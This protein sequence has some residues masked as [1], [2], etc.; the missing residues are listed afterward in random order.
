MTTGVTGGD[1]LEKVRTRLASSGE[2]PTTAAVAAALR[3][4]SGVHGDAEIQRVLTVLRSEIAGAGPLEALLREPDVTDVLVNGPAEIWA[5]R[6][7]GLE[8]CAVSFPGE[9]AVRRLAQRL[10]AASG[11][12]LDD[13]QPHVDARLADGTRLHA[14]LPPISPTGTVLSL[15]VPRRRAFTMA[16]LSAADSVA[17]SLGRVCSLIVR[18]RL[19]FLVTGGTGSGKTTLL[20]ALLGLVDVGERVLLVEDAA[21]LQPACPH[22]VRL[23]ARTSN[24]EGVGEVTLR[25]L[26]RQALR[27][28]PDRIVV[29]EVRG[30]EVLDL[31]TALNTGHEG[32]CGTLHANGADD[33]P[34]RLESL[35]ALAGMPRAALHS[36]LASA[37]R[38]VLHLR[39]DA[40]GVRQLVEVDV[41]TRSADGLVQAD[42]ALRR[43]GPQIRTGPG[44]PRLLGLLTAAGASPESLDLGLDSGTAPP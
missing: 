30:P 5:D 24:V 20:A 7:R 34:A 27:M 11:R 44:W 37:L 19:A 16:E 10:A 4:E 9:A 31:L 25:T 1:L 41:L 35:A 40:S 43:I 17:P 23:E 21:E 29:G 15:R 39:R 26:V 8:R 13:A 32:G 36:Q 6:G 3:Q 14:V 33:V 28:R 38:V 42:P 18:H 22:L 12:R 2:P